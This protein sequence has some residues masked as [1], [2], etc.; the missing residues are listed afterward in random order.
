MGSP[1]RSAQAA[2]AAKPKATRPA[3]T[4]PQPQIA[5]P[6]LPAA[7]PGGWACACGGG[8][9]RCAAASQPGRHDDA[10]EERRADAVAMRIG[11]GGSVNAT[12]RPAD[13]PPALL[14]GPGEPLDRDSRVFFEPRFGTDLSAVRIHRGAAADRLARQIGAL[15][16]SDGPHIGFR[17]GLHAPRSGAGRQLLAHELAH[18]TSRQPTPGRLHRHPVAP[19]PVARRTRTDLF[20]DGTPANTGIDVNT[21]DSCTREQADWF[22]E[23]SLSAADRTLL[24]ELMLK[25]LLG[26][27]VAAGI[28]DLKLK[29]L[30]GLSAAD[31]TGLEAFGRACDPTQHTIRVNTP[32]AYTVAR[33]ASMGHTLIGLESLHDMT[34]E[35][36]EITVS[37]IQL[38]EIDAGGRLAAISAYWTLFE[39]HLQM[40]IAAT[41]A[42]ARGPEFQRVLDLLAGPGGIAPFATLRGRIRNLHRFSRVMLTRLVANYADF[43]RSR[44]VQLVLH[45]GHDSAAFQHSAHLFE[46]L[47]LQAAPP[48]L[49]GLFYDERLVLVLEGGDSLASMTTQVADIAR[50]YG[51][52][53][54]GGRP[55]LEQVMIAGHGSPRSVQMAGSGAPFIHEGEV[56]YPS[57]SLLID[58]SGVPTPA[59]QALLDTLLRSLDPAT[60]RLVFAGCLVASNPVPTGTAQGDIATF[61]A[62]HPN[63][64]SVVA[65]Q[66]AALGLPANFVTASR[67][68]L[69]LGSARSLRDADGNLTVDFP[70]DPAAFGNAAAYAAGGLEPEGVLNAAIEVAGT[71]TAVEVAAILRSRLALAP[72]AG[73]WY[74]MVT[75]VMVGVALDG[76]PAGGPVDVQRLQVLSHLTGTPF[77][78]RWRDYGVSVASFAARVN[79][80][81]ALAGLIYTGLSGTA[82]FGAPPDQ[83]AK[84]MRFIVEQAWI[85]AGTAREAQLLAFV[86]ADAGLSAAILAPHLDTAAIAASAPTLFPAGA[87]AGSGRLRLALAWL[88]RQPA[89]PDVLAFLTSQVTTGAGAPTLSAALRAELGGMSDTSLLR[90]LGI[91]LTPTTVTPPIGGGGGGVSLPSANAEVTGDATNDVLIEQRVY[92][93][94]VLPYALNVRR[95]P[96]MHG[97]VIDALRRGDTVR[98]LGFTHDWAGIEKNGRLGFVYRTQI[99]PP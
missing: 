74:D 2:P 7:M 20:G 58:A 91:P 14:P 12:P 98:V 21:F 83:E 82:I 53:D 13:R 40:R 89:Q 38:D 1:T 46:D 63:L 15:A 97:R 51:Q 75:R 78:A 24:W 62:A 3:G 86:D 88:R 9:P 33:R 77:L 64:A 94:T 30:V 48:G 34:P 28:G 72:R 45:T 10:A 52:R 87:A 90:A 39:P 25:L 59:T 41:P 69:G 76:V 96:G 60:A 81:P 70:A 27:H 66:G 8:C 6:L 35:V 73:D 71:R 85:N 67:A 55:R 4:T 22:A 5:A 23:P 61:I 50:D 56:R 11:A 95:A 80:H 31:W 99:T 44:P 19:A 36:L 57:E 68:S 54:A 18:V 92:E 84:L 43:S 37:E 65:T 93:A 16:F 79:V 17:A 26:A 42:P 47:V 32:G 29:D 49:A